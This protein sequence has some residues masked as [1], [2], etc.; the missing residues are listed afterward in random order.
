LRMVMMCSPSHSGYRCPAD[1]IGSSQ[2][3]EGPV[4]LMHD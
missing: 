3:N 4:R 1:T 2:L